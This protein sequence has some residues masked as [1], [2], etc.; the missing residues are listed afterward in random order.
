MIARLFVNSHRNGVPGRDGN[1]A[2]MT[3]GIVSPR[4]IQNANMP[5]KALVIL[6]QRQSRQ[7]IVWLFDIQSKLGDLNENCQQMQVKQ[8]RVHTEI[9]TSPDFPKQCS[10]VL[11]RSIRISRLV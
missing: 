10:I 5:P 1:M 2:A 9:A 7:R 8:E 3:L 4:M 11:S 6:R